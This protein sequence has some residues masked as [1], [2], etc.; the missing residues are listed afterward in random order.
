M[1]P[2]DRTIQLDRVVPAL[3]KLPR[4][5]GQVLVGGKRTLDIYIREGSEYLKPQLALWLD[6]NW[7]MVLNSEVI[8]PSKS[9]DNGIT[10]TLNGIIQAII[11][12]SPTPPP[13]GS[14]PFPQPGLPERI[15]VNDKA[16]AD[17]ASLL[18]APLGIPVEYSDLPIPVFEEAFAGASVALGADPDKAPLDLLNGYWKMKRICH[19]SM[20]RRLVSGGVN[21]GII[22]GVISPLKWNWV[23]KMVLTTKPLGF[24]L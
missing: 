17:A 4:R 15:M 1:P 19:F 22:P 2:K 3:K 24:T 6:Q 23:L 20:W 8:T 11:G 9:S 18:F 16:L 21:P 10:E 5:Q 12:P 13:P 7:G 14:L